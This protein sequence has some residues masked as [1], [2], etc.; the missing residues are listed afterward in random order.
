[1]TELAAITIEGAGYWYR[2][3]RWVFRGLC[4]SVA[5]GDTLCILGANGRG[6]TTLLRALVGLL[7]LREGKI[8]L[9]GGVSFVPQF[10]QT[11]FQYSVREMVVMGRARHIG[12]LAHPSRADYAI[13]EAMLDRVG[14]TGFAARPFNSLSGGERQL[15]LVARAL[16]TQSEVLVLDEP[17]SSLDLRNQSVLLKLLTQICSADGITVVYTTHHPQHALATN[18]TVLLM[19]E[20][21][22]YVLGDA[23]AVLDENHLAA[24]YG[25]PVR[26]IELDGETGSY[27]GLVPMYV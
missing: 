5:R 3:G 26:R 18:S 9:R 22:R 7:K 10:F 8:V 17:S 4:A 2:G 15:V 23:R 1:M 24:L 21:D 11:A 25:V 14:L 12:L 20:R 27:P 6:K 13:A 19:L 16:A